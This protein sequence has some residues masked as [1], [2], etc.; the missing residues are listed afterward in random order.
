M[1]RSGG[2]WNQDSGDVGKVVAELL[3]VLGAHETRSGLSSLARRLAALKVSDAQ[4][5]PI[6]RQRQREH[7]PGWIA[8]AVVRVLAHAGVP[9]HRQQVHAAVECLL[10]QP[11]SK[12]SVDSCLSGGARRK[13]PQFERVSSGC[14]RLAQT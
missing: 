10:G 6:K 14:Y 11:V 3:G 2:Y 12:D 1:R 9:M 13:K 5:R 8:D 4:P 7:R